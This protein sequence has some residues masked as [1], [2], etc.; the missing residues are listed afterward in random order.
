MIAEADI[1]LRELLDAID[2]CEMGSNSFQNCQKL[3]VLYA[4]YDHL[5]SEPMPMQATV[6]EVE[7]DSYGDSDFLQAVA[8]KKSEEVWMVIDELMET[9][10]ALQ[11]KLYDA[12]L[13]KLNE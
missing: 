9:V 4:I 13:R 10:R 1:L 12:V 5:Y 7:I 11:P 6:R 8:G 2:E 3:A